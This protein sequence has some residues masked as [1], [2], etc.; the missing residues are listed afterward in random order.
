MKESCRWVIKKFTITFILWLQ[1]DVDSETDNTDIS[2]LWE[3]S[4]WGK[5]LSSQPVIFKWLDKSPL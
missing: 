2:V 1:C 4:S 3:I 5:F